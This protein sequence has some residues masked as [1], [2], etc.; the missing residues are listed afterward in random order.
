MHFLKVQKKRKNAS[1]KTVKNGG[2]KTAKKAE[3]SSKTGPL[4]AAS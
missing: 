1:K 4:E 3:N 2:L